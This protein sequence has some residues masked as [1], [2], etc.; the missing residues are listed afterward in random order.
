MAVSTL[1]SLVVVPAFYVLADRG[2]AWLRRGRV[3][4]A[5]AEPAPEPVKAE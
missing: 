2:A 1:L 5:P 3:V 4:A